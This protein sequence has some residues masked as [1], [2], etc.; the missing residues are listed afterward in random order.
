MRAV[1]EH[2]D[3]V[4]AVVHDGKVGHPIAVHVTDRNGG[5]TRTCGEIDGRS[6]GSIPIVQKHADVT[7]AAV[8]DSKVGHSITVQITDCDTGWAGTCGETDRDGE[9]PVFPLF[10]STLTPPL[11][12]S[13]TAKSAFP[14][15]FRSPI[16]TEYGPEP[17]A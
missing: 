8:R 13:A 1:Q 16:A 6:E 14:S 2:A 15:P 7:A 10:R 11:P 4:A 12:L 5:R 17:V 3:V 9:G